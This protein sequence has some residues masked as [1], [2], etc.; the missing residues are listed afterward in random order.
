MPTASPTLLGEPYGT[1]ILTLSVISIEVSLMAA[2]MLTGEANPTLARDTTGRDHDRN[3]L[4]G[5]SAFDQRPAPRRAG[6]QPPGCPGLP[7]H[8]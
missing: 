4:V 7:R 6:V 3:A 8:C 1:L 2:I 5:I